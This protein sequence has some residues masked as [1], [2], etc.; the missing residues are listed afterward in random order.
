MLLNL[1][2]KCFRKVVSEEMVF[3]SGINCIRG[4]NEASKTTRLE[5]IGYVL[6]GTRALRTPIEDAVTWGEDV[7]NLTAE[8]DMSVGGEILTFKRSKSGAE[9]VKNGAVFVTGQ[10][11]VSAYAA[12]I[13]CAD[14]NTGS[15]L[16]FA[17]QGAIR[18]ALEAGPKA[19]SD[20]IEDLAGFTIFDQILEKAQDKLTLGAPGILE[21]RLKGA[22]ATLAAATESL[23][24]KPDDE[25]FQAEITAIANSIANIEAGI[26]ALETASIAASDAFSASSEQYLK[27]TQL[28]N[29]IERLGQQIRQSEGEAAG[30]S[31]NASKPM[32]SLDGLKAAVA[33]AEQWENASMAYQSFKKLT[34]C[35]T[36]FEGTS[37]EFDQHKDKVAAELK[38]NRNKLIDIDRAID[39][40]Q[41]RRINHD[42]CDKCGQDVTHLTS[43]IE[44]NVAVDA[45]V[46]QLKLDRDVVSKE[47]D[48][49]SP[50]MAELDAWAAIE[51]QNARLLPKISQYVTIGDNSVPARVYWNGSIPGD[52]GPDVASYRRE[53]EKAEAEVKAIERAKVSLD[54]VNQQ[55]SDL[56]EKH[57]ALC[58]QRDAYTGPNCDDILKLDEA[59]AEAKAAVSAAEGRILIARQELAT[60]TTQHEAAQRMWSLAQARVSDAEK[61]IVE[62]KRGLEELSFNNAL[63]KKLRAIRP[64]I[65]NQVWNATLSSV[66]VM[67]S[68]MRGEE[69]WVTKEKSG[70]CVN[71][72]AIESLSGSTLDLLGISLRVALMKT[73]MPEC[74][75]LSLDEPAQGCDQ[76]RTESLLGFIAAC[77]IK[78]TILITHESVSET[79]ADNLIDIGV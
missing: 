53:L 44:T 35:E 5:A 42:K 59:K 68:Q 56:N 55:L 1:R 78:Q 61:L 3:T 69:S 72:K 34:A 52:E 32:P 16:M 11:E 12:R 70:F 8:L 26:P 23:P 9:V 43:V 7:K 63:V 33:D 20:L 51:N 65:A 27:H 18:G 57:L 79:V 2:L 62:T 74:D 37:E 17:H 25:A 54:V 47:I 28:L 76:A 31:A 38:A 15:K 24:I 4:A 45:E 41:R 75:L 77:G 29:E 22:E 6:F 21:E 40:A 14:V 73:F 60:L 64:L 46:A 19:L 48:L 10:Q 67:F 66:S 13:F 30:H 39:A 50:L 49:L 58:Q 71:G 36:P